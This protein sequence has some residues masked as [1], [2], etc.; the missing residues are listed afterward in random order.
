V[1]AELKAAGEKLVAVADKQAAIVEKAKEAGSYD[2]VKAEWDEVSKEVSDV[3]AA[4]RPWGEKYGSG[5]LSDADKA[6]YMKVVVPAASKSAS[7][8]LD[9]L[10]LIK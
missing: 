4:L 3:T 5:E 10:E 8:G 7:A 9:M 6:Y 2:A 1:S